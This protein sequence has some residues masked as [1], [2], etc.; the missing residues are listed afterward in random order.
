[1]R[2]SPSVIVLA[3]MI[4]GA[5]SGASA[6]QASAP[7]PTEQAAPSAQSYDNTGYGHLATPPGGVPGNAAFNN[8]VRKHTAPLEA[9]GGR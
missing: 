6:Q 1:M 3:F 8:Q 4:I 7:R 9:N 5:S 2:V